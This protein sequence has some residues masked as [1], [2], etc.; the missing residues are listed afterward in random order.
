MWSPSHGNEED[1]VT[2]YDSRLGCSTISFRHQP[3]PDALATIADLG[4]REIDLG[5]LPGVCDHVPYVLDDARR[6]PGR[7]VRH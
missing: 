1:G 2:R 5:A 6:G 3:L 4:F 7:P